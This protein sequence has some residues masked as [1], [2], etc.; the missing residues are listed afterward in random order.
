ME[1]ASTED[2]V[3]RLSAC[4]FLNEVVLGC[5]FKLQQR[6]QHYSAGE[7]FLGD[8]AEDRGSLAEAE[9]EELVQAM[10]LKEEEDEERQAGEEMAEEE[11]TLQSEVDASAVD[12]HVASNP[13]EGYY[14]AS[15]SSQYFYPVDAWHPLDGACIEAEISTDEL[16]GLLEGYGP[17]AEAV[18]AVTGGCLSGHHGAFVSADGASVGFSGVNEYAYYD[19]NYDYS[20]ACQENTG[21]MAGFTSCQN[22]VADMSAP[23]DTF[24]RQISLNRREEDTDG[25]EVAH[26]SAVAN[27]AQGTG[28]KQRLAHSSSSKFLR[29]ISGANALNESASSKFLR[30]TSCATEAG[31]DDTVKGESRQASKKS[32][33]KSPP[34]KSK[35]S[36]ARTQ[37]LAQP[38]EDAADKQDEEACMAPVED[39]FVENDLYIY[40][41]PSE[42]IDKLNGILDIASPRTRMKSAGHTASSSQMWFDPLCQEQQPQQQQHQQARQLL[43]PR[44]PSWPRASIGSRGSSA[45]RAR[46]RRLQV[47]PASAS[48]AA[49]PEAEVAARADR[50]LLGSRGTS[51][52]YSA[53]GERAVSASSSRVAFTAQLPRLSPQAQRRSPR[54]PPP[55]SPARGGM[56]REAAGRKGHAPRFGGHFASAASRMLVAEQ[57]W[58][59]A[60]AALASALGK[61]QAPQGFQAS[62][63][64]YGEAASTLPRVAAVPPALPGPEHFG[65]PEVIEGEPFHSAQRAAQDDTRGLRALLRG[66]EA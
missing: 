30:A 22:N 48:A 17:L 29:A 41:K 34:R 25:R 6:D 23:S 19:P 42:S 37:R 52:G 60:E 32:A 55:R 7:R 35:L 20:R 14:L 4:H 54:V 45:A 24:K 62:S 5:V 1:E 61:K 16:A 2:I 47:P 11:M 26:G 27:A 40:T 15:D 3:A 43:Q 38:S 57:E 46:G 18:A 63:A 28:A 49:P 50:E 53:E 21:G 9:T 8:D 10:L 64:A 39:S 51:G 59:S 66:R 56:G 65:M 13:S 58:Q 36:K 33:P 12:V 44:V 31:E